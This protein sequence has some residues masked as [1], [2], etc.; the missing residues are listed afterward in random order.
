MKEVK[1]SDREARGLAPKKAPSNVFESLVSQGK[2]VLKDAVA[3]VQDASVPVLFTDYYLLWVATAKFSEEESVY[4]VGAF[5]RWFN[6][7]S[8]L[9]HW[10]VSMDRLARQAMGQQHDARR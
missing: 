2:K 7:S 3:D 9:I 1:A 6:V 5:Q 10:V 4:Y 8:G